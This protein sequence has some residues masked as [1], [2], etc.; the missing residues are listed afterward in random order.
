MGRKILRTAHVS[1][2]NELRI[3]LTDNEI[4]QVRTNAKAEGV[5]T[6]IWVEKQLSQFINNNDRQ[7]NITKTAKQ[8]IS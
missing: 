7:Q 1:F 4:E 8:A 3:R 5:S 6:P 2:L